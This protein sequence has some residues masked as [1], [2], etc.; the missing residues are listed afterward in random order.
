MAGGSY[1]TL[2]YSKSTVEIGSEIGDLAVR[3]P[4]TILHTEAAFE[5]ESTQ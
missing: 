1:H 3:R 4:R 5:P 2:K